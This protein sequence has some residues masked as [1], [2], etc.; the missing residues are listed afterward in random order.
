MVS[1]EIILIVIQS[2]SG[3]PFVLMYNQGFNMAL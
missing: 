1:V 2:I 3:T